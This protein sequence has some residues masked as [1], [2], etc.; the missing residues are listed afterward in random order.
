LAAGEIGPAHARVITEIMDAMP[1]STTIAQRA[2][3]EADL[4]RH[5]R[6]FGPTDLVKL[7]RHMLA[8]TSIRTAP[9]P[10]TTIRR[11]PLGSSDCATAATGN[12]GSRDGSTGNTAHSS[13]G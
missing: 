8:R 7:G 12:S 9:N 10:A 2:E 5:A 3:V 1:A 13:R 4:A 11:P 6:T